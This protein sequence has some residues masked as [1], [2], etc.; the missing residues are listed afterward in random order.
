MNMSAS[1]S[2]AYIGRLIGVV[3]V[4]GFITSSMRFVASYISI[5]KKSFRIIWIID[6]IGAGI[7]VVLLNRPDSVVFLWQNME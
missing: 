7:L 1:V 2:Y 4:Y 3:G 5:I 6:V